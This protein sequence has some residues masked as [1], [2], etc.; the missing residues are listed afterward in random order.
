MAHAL[1]LPHFLFFVTISIYYLVSC[2][3]GSCG[4]FRCGN[5][6]WDYPFGAKDS[7]CGDPT[8]LLECDEEAKMPLITI[9][10]YQY[11]IL[12]PKN[13]FHL[14]LFNEPTMIILYKHLKE[15]E[16]NLSES[17]Y[18]QFWSANQ[19]RIA[20][21]YT[22]IT[23]GTT[24]TVENA[25]P[26]GG[27]LTNLT[28]N[29]YRYVNVS[30]PDLS[31]VCASEFRIAVKEI[32]LELGKPLSEITG[33]GV[34]I[35]WY[36]GK[37]CKY[38]ETDYRNCTYRRTSSF[39]YCHASSYSQCST[40]N[41]RTAV[42][43]SA[44]IGSG[45]LF[46]AAVLL[47]V[48]YRKRSLASKELQLRMAMEPSLT[49]VEQFLDD[50]AHEMPIRYSFSQLKKITNNFADKLGEGGFGVVYKGKLPRGNL[51][52]VKI[53]D[54]SRHSETQFMNEVAT[55]GRIH[56]VHLV[57]LMGY[58]F[59]GFRSALVYEYMVNGS[60]EKFIFAGKNKGRILKVEQLYSIA[61]GAARGIAYLHQDC[62]RSI[63]HFDIKPHNILLDKDFIPK[64]AD[65]GLAKLFSREDDHISLTAAR[66]TPGYVA[67]ELW[68][69]NLGPVTHKSDV[70]SFGMVLLEMAGGRKNIDVQ[71]S[72]S[73]QL[74]FP[75]WAFKLMENTQLEMM[76]RGSGKAE[77]ESE[78]MEKAI[79]LAKVGLWCIQYNSTDRPCMSR[80]VQMLEGNGDVSNPPL[81]FNSSPDCQP[82]LQYSTEEFSSMV[83]NW[84]CVM[85]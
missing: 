79:R 63:I 27:G 75:E 37:P 19:F 32:D 71:V 45:L 30:L 16:C 34:N 72:R 50:F 57:R 44:A 9:G 8:L 66:G 51:V 15:E 7:G 2:C 26:N 60:L 47:V 29:G 70:Y 22:N 58:C 53:L 81:P 5:Y 13:Y 76:L 4:M 77:I 52:A 21:G 25:G 17:I 40:G 82:A 67:P 78:Q 74:Y 35:T 69:T 42:I 1:R 23:L 14:V 31:K 55:V 43:L 80:V 83:C 85:H 20:D 64:I 12:E 84:P 68:F 49:K 11:Y 65:F 73:S 56:H 33:T 24:C 62:E 46:L 36:P 39:C 3:N 10:A 6:T 54:Q 18:D 41:S 48:F 59:E 28:C 61:L 38:C